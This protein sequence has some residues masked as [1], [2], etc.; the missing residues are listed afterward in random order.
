[1]GTPACAI[2][3]SAQMMIGAPPSHLKNAAG[4]IA[5]DIELVHMISDKILQLE[6]VYNV[7]L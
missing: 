7:Q 2:P 4:P 1:M 3:S 5:V 6:Y